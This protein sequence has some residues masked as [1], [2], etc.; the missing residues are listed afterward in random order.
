LGSGASALPSTWTRTTSEPSPIGAY[1]ATTAGALVNVGYANQGQAL[2][3]RPEL[4]L[5]IN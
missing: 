2:R 5:R 4:E 1:I 3:D